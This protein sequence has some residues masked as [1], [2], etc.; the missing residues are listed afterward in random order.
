MG[1][2]NDV[3]ISAKEKVN[4]AKVPFELALSALE[5]MDNNRAVLV[6]MIITMFK[7][8]HPDFEQYF[9]IS[10]M[11]KS[12]MFPKIWIVDN[13]LRIEGRLNEHDSLLNFL[14]ENTK[15]NQLQTV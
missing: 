4:T 5:M 13:N 11:L 8:M 3:I 1:K 12:N 15:N 9:T 2:T 14:N 10:E 6:D 7:S